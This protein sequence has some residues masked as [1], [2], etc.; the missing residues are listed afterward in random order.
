MTDLFWAS[1]IM[2]PVAFVLFVPFATYLY[3]V[4]TG[5]R[6]R[7]WVLSLLGELSD[8]TD[9]SRG[10][11]LWAI[12][13]VVGSQIAATSLVL[14]G[15]GGGPSASIALACGVGEWLAA[16]AWLGFLRATSSPAGN[17]RR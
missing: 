8:G 17:S 11:I 6:P 3:A 13:W 10:S 16:L 9:R 15:L 1:V 7:R 5:S 12:A 14:D 4:Q 2:A